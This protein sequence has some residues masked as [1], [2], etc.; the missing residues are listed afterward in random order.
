MG[1]V[2][3]APSEGRLY[4]AF[5]GGRTAAGRQPGIAKGGTGHP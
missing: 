3:E 1:E 4:A 5:G 2:K